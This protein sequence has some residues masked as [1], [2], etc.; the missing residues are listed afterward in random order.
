MAPTVRCTACG[1]RSDGAFCSRCG[2]ALAGRRTRPAD[3]RT[4]LIAWLLA[5]A[6]VVWVSAQ[7]LRGAPEPAAPVM[8]NAG[9]QGVGVA[10]PADIRALGPRDRFDRLF[11]RLVRA[12]AQGDSITVANMSSMALDAYAEL[13]SV[14]ADTRF[15]AALI[16]IQIGDF[17]G[18][19]ALA[20]TLE[21]RAPGHLFGPI[22]L[23]ALA[24]LEG[25]TAGARRAFALF[26]E[27]A[28]RELARSDR[29]EYLEHRQLLTEFQQ[30]AETK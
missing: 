5:A 30:A 2:G 16:A 13:D 28:T 19:R 17:P 7:V 11:D 27:H 12:G 23:G 22:L 24:R 6:A 4:W 10:P 8:S 29:P 26:R 21:L 18:A 1:T 3:R 25:D 14:D 20:D 15:H 9:S